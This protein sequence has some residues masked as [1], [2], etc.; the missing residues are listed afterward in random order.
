MGYVSAKFPEAITVKGIYTVF[1]REICVDEAFGRM[2]VHDFPEI[3]YIE[4]GENV[5]LV[6]GKEVRLSAGQAL[7][8]APNTTHVGKGPRK[9]SFAIISFDVES[10]ILSSVY[11]RP[12]TLSENQE[13]MLNAVVD[14]GCACFVQ[15]PKWKSDESGMILRDGAD[16]Y[17]LQ[18]MKKGFEL[19][20]ISLVKDGAKN[21]VAKERTDKD[22]E[23]A[24]AFLRS[25]VYCSLTVREIA[26]GCGMSVSKLKYLF[27]DNFGGGV[28]DC[29]NKIKTEEAKKLIKEGKYNLTEISDR[30]AF[31]SLHYFSRLFK[32][33]VGI[34]PS[35]YSKNNR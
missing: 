18:R 7:I 34:S 4:S 3:I 9:C 5:L 27:R 6:D 15:R 1:R 20:L 19:F 26:D 11:N 28:I 29:F 31:S 33:T 8:Y 12:I 17:L 23:N 2:D 21:I 35:E 10:E 13:A 14:D 25:K 24:L 30:L 22:Y 16:E 32:K